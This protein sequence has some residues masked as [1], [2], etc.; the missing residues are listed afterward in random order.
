M[1]TESTAAKPAPPPAGAQWLGE[2]DPHHRDRVYLFPA[3]QVDQTFLFLTGVQTIDGRTA[4]SIGVRFADS[5]PRTVALD[6]MP[7]Q[8]RQLA[9]ALIAQ[10]D[11]AER[12]DGIGRD[13]TSPR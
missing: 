10:A 3:I 13:P 5:P 12:V 1:S 2:W 9:R 8:A 4:T 7:E 6:L 11:A